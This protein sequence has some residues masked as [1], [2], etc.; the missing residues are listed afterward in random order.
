MRLKNLFADEDAVSPVIGVIL[1]VAI[2]VILAAVIASVVLGVGQQAGNVSPQASFTIEYESGAGY[3]GF[4]GNV[5]VQHDSGD[6]IVGNRLFFR[7]SGFD[8]QAVTNPSPS[9]NQSWSGYAGNSS[10]DIS[11]STTKEGSPA[12]A[13]G[14]QANIGADG[15]YELSLV[16][17]APDQDS[18]STL[19]SDEGPDA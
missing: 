18:S 5:S 3:G 1:M 14:D 7:G 16:W 2:T 13:A 12:V 11:Q 8:T 9:L 17:E 6:T 15:D 4:E 19:A 10:I